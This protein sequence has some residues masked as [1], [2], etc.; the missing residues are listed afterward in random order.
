MADQPP[1]NAAKKSKQKG[2]GIAKLFR[3]VI[4]RPKSAN[5]S[6]S[7]SNLTRVSFP[8]TV[9]AHDPVAENDAGSSEPTVASKYIGSSLL[10]STT[11]WL[12]SR[13]KRYLESGYVLPSVIPRRSCGLS[14]PSR[15]YHPLPASKTIRRWSAGFLRG[16]R[17]VAVR[18][19][20]ASER[21]VIEHILKRTTPKSTL[22][23]SWLLQNRILKR[24]PQIGRELQKTVLE[25]LRGLRKRSLRSCR[26][27]SIPI[28][29]G[30]HSPLLKWS[31]K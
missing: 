21:Y 2:G 14:P 8:P 12:L 18:L 6:A 10:L 1:S 4:R 30:W 20:F 11:T 28:Q 27:V 24:R 26:T 22:L 29:S 5:D 17:W 19:I 3:D 31:L 15:S 16:S 23:P 9:G 13:W 25:W 7:Q